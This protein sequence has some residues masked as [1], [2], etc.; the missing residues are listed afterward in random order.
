MLRIS[1]SITVSY[2]TAS[3]RTFLQTTA[4]KFVSKFF[5][6]FCGSLGV[7]QLVATAYYPHTNRQTRQLNKTVMTRLRRC[8]AEHQP[9]WHE[10]IQPLTYAYNTQIQWYTTTAMYNIVLSRL[11]PGPS[12]RY[13]GSSVPTV[14][15]FETPTQAFV[16][17]AWSPP[18]ILTFQNG[19]LSEKKTTAIHIK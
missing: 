4:Q 17:T 8:V 13:G 7:K 11:S 10:F 1:S 5:A 3:I 6:T 14:A 18:S 2:R 16:A 9:Y 12:T 15:H 19:F